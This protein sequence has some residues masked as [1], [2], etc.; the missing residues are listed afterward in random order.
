MAKSSTA[1]AALAAVAA[2]ALAVCGCASM[3]GDAHDRVITMNDL[4]AAVRPLAEREV[5]G[6]KIIEVEEEKEGGK[7]VYSITYDQAGTKM[8]VEFSPDGKLLSKGK[9]D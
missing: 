1:K 3:H 2:G 5:A 8:E 6:C 7:V 4:P 9:D